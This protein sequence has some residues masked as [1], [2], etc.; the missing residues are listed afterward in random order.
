MKKTI[1]IGITGGIAAYKA[2]DLISN[3]KKLDFDIEVVMS[4]NASKFITPLTIGALINKPVIEDEFGDDGYLIKHIYLAKKADLFIIAPGSADIIAKIANGIC[5]DALTS[6]WLATTCPKIVA[7]AMNTNMYNNP[8]T[9]RNLDIL[10][11]DGVLIVEPDN[12]IL[13]CG[14][15]GKGKLAPIS[16]IVECCEYSLHNHCLAGRKLLVNAG[17]TQEALD[18]VRFI[19]N[20]SSGKMGYAIAQAGVNYGMDVTLVSGPSNLPIPFGL[21]FISVTSA[22]EMTDIMKANA[23]TSDYIVCAAAVS[24]YVPKNYNNQKI[25]KDED[26]ILLSLKKSQDILQYLGDN[27]LPNQV[28]CGFAMETENLIKNAKNK[29][30]KKNCDLLVAND[31]SQ[32]GAGFKGDTNKVTFITKNFVEEKELKTKKQLGYDIIDK[33]RKIRGE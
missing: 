2:C 6:T 24:D 28:L 4:K 7:P 15:V 1:L 22:K 32:T 25:K 26:K 13:A 10:K 14:D 31:L 33:L 16:K 29:F 21:N 30:V 17:P 5:D 11:K 3:L 18:P 19:S 27:K 9:K 20:H 12:G 23:L 8:A